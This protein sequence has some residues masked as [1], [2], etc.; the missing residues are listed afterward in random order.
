MLQRG[1]V[2]VIQYY[3]R[4]ISSLKRRRCAHRALRGGDSCSEFAKKVVLRSGAWRGLSLSARRLRECGVAYVALKSG[5]SAKQDDRG[6]SPRTPRS[7]LAGSCGRELLGGSGACLDFLRRSAAALGLFPSAKTDERSVPTWRGCLPTRPPGNVS[8]DSRDRHD[9][10]ALPCTS[11]EAG[12]AEVACCALEAL[13]WI[14][15]AIAV[16]AG[17]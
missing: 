15:C 17:G 14:V 2:A 12:P 10:M 6:S 1:I 8:V 16:L 7:A 9:W 11:G 13:F 3:Q 4:H 5:S